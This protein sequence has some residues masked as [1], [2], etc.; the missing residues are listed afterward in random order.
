MDIPPR[1]VRAGTV[2]QN[3]IVHHRNAWATTIPGVLLERHG[4]SDRLCEVLASQA[5][6]VLTLAG[7]HNPVLQA[8]CL[9]VAQVASPDRR[10]SKAPTGWPRQHDA[11]KYLQLHHRRPW[12]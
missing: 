5:P 6:S 12:Q 1:Y 8:C 7:L 2:F 4:R 11:V 3:K 9:I 10:L